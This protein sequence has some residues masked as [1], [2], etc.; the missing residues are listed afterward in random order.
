MNL[1]ESITPDGRRYLAAAQQRVARPFHYRWLIPK[2][3]K[4]DGKRWFYGNRIATGA[5]LP[6][7]WWYIGGTQGI[8]AAIA[9]CGLAGVWRFNR[10]HPVLVDPYGMLCALLSADCF[11]HHL[12]PL[13]L[14]L[15]LLGGCVRETSP[16]WAALYAWNPLALIGVLPVAVRHLQ[17][18]G[19][20][21]LGEEDRWILDHPVRASRKYHAGFPLSLYVLPWGVALLALA[22]PS[23]QLALALIAG[24]AQCAIAT[25]TVRLY[26]WSFPV[27]LASA[28]AVV[29]T[30]ALAL[31]VVLA[32]VNP[33][34]SEGL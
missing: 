26:Q 11:H 12:V 30:H 28:V 17:R 33:F 27:V 20:D 4:Q 31:F 22:H 1:A 29:P 21:V 32:L 15:A 23:P 5:L 24:Y 3:F 18:E 6:A 25:D 8:A 9:V 19:N 13:G 14:A 10:A 2:L 34:A 16:V 7:T